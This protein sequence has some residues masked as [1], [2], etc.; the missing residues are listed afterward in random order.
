[1]N[2][3]STAIAAH[4]LG[5][6]YRLGELRPSP[7]RVTDA[8]LESLGRLLGAGRRRRDGVGEIWALRDLS[9]EVPKG[10]TLGVIGRNG[11]GKSTLLKVLARITEPTTGRVVIRGRVRAIIEVGTGFHLELTGRENVFLS[12]A[13]LG[14]SRA[15]IRRK[16]DQIV[17][18]AGTE[19]FLD[20]PVKRYSSG[21]KV[22]L[23]FSVAAHLD[24]EVLLIDEVLAVGDTEF[25]RKCLGRM[26]EIARSGRTILFVSHNLSAVEN[27]CDR[28]IW[29]D[30]GRLMAD[31]EPPAVVTKYLSTRMQV[32]DPV[33]VPPRKGDEDAQCHQIRVVG[34]DGTPRTSFRTT[35]PIFIEFDVEVRRRDPS[36][37]VAFDLASQEG[38]TLFRTFH[39][40]LTPDD[41]IEPGRWVFR[42]TLH[43]N[44]LNDGVY[45]VHPRIMIR[46]ARAIVWA[47]D[48]LQFEV[49]NVEGVG[50]HLGQARPGL[51][52]PPLAWEQE[53]ARDAVAQRR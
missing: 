16:F 26:S 13:T 24:P 4:G 32:A 43:E 28:A 21:M 7:T 1:M 34:A 5:K 23:A 35:E 8:A 30:R 51:V 36:M 14:M 38:V 39:D 44:L 41:T 11:S 37:T 50:S 18:F 48:V 29:L 47:D 22:R 45:S 6:R 19:D 33:W 52:L 46:N 2:P 15:E 40:D 49:R 20:T 12:G 10:Q 3:R 17:A 9:L 25:Q 53:P 31:G 42:C 27:L